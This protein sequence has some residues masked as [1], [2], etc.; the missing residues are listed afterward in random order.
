MGKA[1]IEDLVHPAVDQHQ[2]G[3]LDVAVDDVGGVG[4]GQAAQ[5]LPGVNHMR[6]LGAQDLRHA[7][8]GA[9]RQDHS[10]RL[11]RFDEIR[12]D[13]SMGHDLGA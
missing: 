3:R 12:R 4:R 13:V 6:V 8:G 7:R 1:E 10:V 2:V 5:H 11:L 9:G